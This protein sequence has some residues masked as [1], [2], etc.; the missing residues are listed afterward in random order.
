MM[1]RVLSQYLLIALGALILAACSGTQTQQSGG[2]DQSLTPQ[3][4]LEEAQV[5]EF[6]PQLLHTA[7]LLEQNQLIP[8]ASILSELDPGKLVPDDQARYGLLRARLHYQQGDDIAAL[9][10]IEQALTATPGM[11]GSMLWELQLWQIQLMGVTANLLAGAEQADR[12]LLTE[13]DELRREHLRGLIWD[14]LQRSPLQELQSGYQ[15]AANPQWQG[16]L[17]L[18]LAASQVMRSPENQAAAVESWANSHPHHP[19]ATLLPGGLASLAELAAAQ[20]RQLAIILPLS[21]SLATAGNAVLDG[22]LAAYYSSLEQGW[23]EI[24]LRVMDSTA[25]SDFNAAYSEAVS[26]GAE[27]VIG[28]LTK[29]R[30]AQW[31]G[32]GATVPLLALNRFEIP[33][34]DSSATFQ[35]GLAPEDEARQLAQ[36]AFE[37]GGRRAL[38]IHSDAAWGWSMAKTLEERWLELDG[39]I[40]ADAVYS[41]REDYSARLKAAL[42]LSDSEERARDIRQAMGTKVEFNPRRRQD[43]DSIFLLSGKP[44]EARSIKPLLAFHYAGDLP[45]YSSS[46]IFSGHRDP[47]R[48]RDLNGIRLVEI[49]WLV[50]T[51][52]PLRASVQSAGG[53]DT[54]A[55]MYALGADAFMLH[56]RLPQLAQD[57]HS[58]VRGQTGLLSMDQEGRLRRELTPARMRSGLPVALSST[59]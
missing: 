34:L 3:E 29:S 24:Q 55:A 53:V 46:H 11:A 58:R 15:F 7:E 40:Q 51:D 41:S 21:G 36:L 44:E 19:A 31:H 49:P 57:P 32:V 54:L 6:T 50:D 16:W 26:G 47:Q 52:N 13:G 2:T 59:D 1:T 9:A 45:V 23:P 18:A 17:E 20:P 4:Q 56:W 25:W 33:P 39:Q 5:T 10:S 43:I 8:A 22:F 42:M 14:A 12:L 37:Q 38:L 27:L 30:L 28:P 35:F 48:D